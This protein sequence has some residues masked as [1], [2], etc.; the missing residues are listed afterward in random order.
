MKIRF[1]ELSIILG[2]FFLINGS[3]TL[4]WPW[5][6][7]R[8]TGTTGA[9]CDSG[10][11]QDCCSGNLRVYTGATMQY[12]ISYSTDNSLLGYIRTGAA[13]W[14]DVA[15]STFTF[16]EGPQ[17]SVWDYTYDGIN[18]INID[19]SFCTHNPGYCGGGILGFSGTWTSSFPSYHAVESDVILN[20]QEWSWGDGT[21]G[22]QN[23]IA[24]TAHE[25]GHDAGLTHPG[26]TCRS[27]GSSGC[28]P[29]FP[30][31]TMYWNYSGGQPTDKASLELDDV[32][33]LIYGYPL[34]TLRV[35][36]LDGGASP[37]SGATVEL[38]GTASPVNGSSIAQGGSVY[39]DIAASLVGDGV[40]SS[41]YVNS[42]PFNTTDASGYTNYIYPV[43]QSFSV[44]A[45]KGIDTVTEAIT[46]AAGVSTVTVQF[47]SSCPPCPGG[48]VVL[49]GVTYPSG[50]T[51]GCSSTTILLLNV[52][53]QNNAIVNFTASTSITVGSGTTFQNG[54]NS[55]LTSPST[56]FQP[57]SHVES[58]AVLN[59]GQ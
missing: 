25:M 27:S 52:T 30:A 45:T 59:V 9:G 44:T 10:V 1:K 19:S 13:K 7:I 6:W 37:V 23:T 3:P 41:T 42:T 22:T 53:V 39:G 33:S 17:T 5:C 14:N 21:G 12:R 35:R 2:V 48:A 34:S 55:T 16:T 31:A 56:T 4:G 50:T 40:S 15:M 20:G 57:G 32:A 28:G 49:N 24:V 43:A 11:Q 46:A 38:I 8:D 47:A 18:L 51:C 36:V 26:S 58:G 29:E 54:S